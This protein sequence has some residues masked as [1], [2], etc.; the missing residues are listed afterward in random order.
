MDKQQ[1]IN[2]VKETFES[3]FEKRQFIKFVKNLLN[4]YEVAEI[5][6]TGNYIPDSFKN[7]VSKY[8]RLGIYRDDDDHRID[9]LIVYLKH[10]TSL[11]HAR[12][13]QRNFIA[14]YLQGT[15]MFE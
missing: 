2:I 5:S 14:G 11:E 4:Q 15:G 8:E 3:Q 10:E 12:S 13:M 9:I 1:A 7:Y 6:R